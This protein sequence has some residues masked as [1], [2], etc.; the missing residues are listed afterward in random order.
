MIHHQGSSLGQAKGEKR[1]WISHRDPK[2]NWRQT[3]RGGPSTG[4]DG[5]DPKPGRTHPY[6]E[7]RRDPRGTQPR[8]ITLNI[9]A[10]SQHRNFWKEKTHRNHNVDYRRT[11][12]GEDERY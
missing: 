8:N 12:C 3:H 4:G 6:D 5:K 7:E 9:H 11:M 10:E 1:G 2:G